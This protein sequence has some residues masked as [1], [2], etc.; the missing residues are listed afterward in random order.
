MDEP[1]TLAMLLGWAS[2]A[3]SAVSVILALVAIALSWKFWKTG[4][5]HERRSKE[6]LS[7]IETHSKV[8]ETTSKEFALPMLQQLL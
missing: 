5:E 2:L 4:S 1:V 7:E 8:A 3:A 6:I